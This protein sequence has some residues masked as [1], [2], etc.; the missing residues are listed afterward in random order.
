M[1]GLSGQGVHSVGPDTN[2]A[3]SAADAKNISSLLTG[4]AWN[5]FNITYSFPTASTQYGTAVSYGSSE[6]FT[7]FSTLEL[8][9]QQNEV[10]RAFDLIESYTD[11]KFVFLNETA[12]SHA[13]IR[14]ANT[15]A[16]DKFGKPITSSTYNPSNP[17]LGHAGD[18]F[19]GTTGRNPA[20]G[21]FDSSQAVL[22]EIGH[23]LGLEHGQF[24]P[25]GEGPNTYGAMN[26]DR[27]DIE[28][29]VM[30]YP[31]YIGENR[32][33]PTAVTFPRTYMMY[34]IAALQYMYGADFSKAGQSATYKWSSLGVETIN[35]VSQGTPVNSV[36][37][38][39]VWT[40]G[41]TSTFD[42]SNF[43]QNQV[44]DMNPGKWM[45]FSDT[46]LADLDVFSADPT[47][48]ARANVYNA[49]AYNGDPRSLID[50]I[51]TGSGNDTITGNIVDNIIRA[52]AGNDNIDGGL[53]ID[54]AVFSGPRSAYRITPLPTGVQVSGPDGTDTLTSIE[55][56]KFDDETLS[57]PLPPSGPDL[58]FA[59]LSLGVTSGPVN[60]RTTLTY[61]VTNL[62]DTASPA[63]MIVI[64]YSSDNTFSSNDVPQGQLAVPAISPGATFTGSYSPFY[65]INT[66]NSYLIAVVDPLNTVVEWDETNNVSNAIALS[67]DP[68][69]PDLDATLLSLI[70]R[71]GVENSSYL[72][73]MSLKSGDSVTVDYVMGNGGLATAPASVVGI[74]R[75]AL[76]GESGDVLLATRSFGALA[77]GAGVHDSF[78][79]ALGTPGTYRIYA[80]ADYT[81]AIPETDGNFNNSSN[82]V[83]V[84]VAAVNHAPV[85]ASNGGGATATISIEENTSSVTTATATDPDA[86]TTLTYSITGGADAARFQINGSTGALSF[87]SAPNFE[88]PA[89][90]DHNNSYLVQV[91]A[92]DGS[93]TDDQAIT[94]NVTDVAERPH[95]TA[96]TTIGVH[97]PG[98]QISGIGDFNHDGT[99]DVLWYNPATRDT[100]IWSLNSGQWA[101]SSTIGLHPAGYNIAGIGDFNRDGTSDVLWYNPA[102]RDTDIWAV[103]NGHWAGS[104]TIGL[105]PPG[106]DIAGIGDFNADGTSDVLWYNP[107]TRDTDIWSLNNG[108]WAGSSTI[109][110][111]PPGY[112]IA[113]IGDF[114]H[115]GT[116]D[117]LWTN[118]TTNETDIW[119]LSNGHWAGS[120]TIGA[121]PAGYRVAGTGDFNQDGTSDA[122]WY[123]PSNN[124]VDVWLVQNGQWAGSASLGAHPP[125]SALAGVSDFDHNAVADIM[126]RDPNTGNV[127]TWLIANS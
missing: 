67:V 75:T 95:W 112:N 64:Y 78:S 37:F 38:E 63:T 24:D 125:G 80:V 13:T 72:E 108:H 104:T 25:N 110:L 103:N 105:H 17:V 126:W 116:S 86:G 96:S 19:F 68:K 62:G 12:S 88:Q 83:L 71:S 102:T 58:R 82:L 65:L 73:A 123:N 118:P 111:H 32:E 113:G 77:V 53:G 22:H 100:D 44:D 36:I 52:G 49:L 50:N 121:H 14:F 84:T 122:V 30:N 79:L 94:V 20:M 9:H 45:R 46:Q 127:E 60:T 34:D 99:G 47:R 40:A 26:D 31:N 109:G 1:S 4:I 51:I 70:S 81:D 23:A 15:T 61:S 85:I 8:D 74:Y 57:W 29:S 76:D 16:L 11:L 101:G 10:R 5:G 97:S 114:N 2:L 56:L 69:A 124:D 106:Y 92:S 54:T 55:K 98:Y 115:D 39:T 3:L 33:G 107:T 119:L 87:V 6:P 27:L 41:A 21:N 66:G 117:V 35:G 42:L 7:G 48:I 43:S 89:D 28:F 18:V 91:R 120:T 59:A 90:A 93:L